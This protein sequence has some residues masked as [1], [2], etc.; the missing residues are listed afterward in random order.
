MSY[1]SRNRNDNQLSVRAGY[2]SGKLYHYNGDGNNFVQHIYTGIM[3]FTHMAGQREKYPAKV[4][5]ASPDKERLIASG[6][7]NRS[8]PRFLADALYDFVRTTSHSLFMHGI[9]LFEVVYEKDTSGN[10][11]SFKFEHIDEKYLF[12]LFGSY[13]QII[14]W[15]IA[16]QSHVRVQIVKIP[17]EKVFRIEFPK[18]LG[19]KRRLQRVLKR[20]WQLSK[21]IIPK[22]QM[23]AMGENK[24]IGFNFEDYKR[25]KYL[26]AATVTSCFGWNQ[27]QTSANYITEYYWFLRY[28]REVKTQTLVREEII[29][30]LNDCLSG[31]VL[32]LAV[33][34]LVE[35]LPTIALIEEQERLMKKGDMKFIDVY[36]S[37]KI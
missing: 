6:I 37:L 21:E 28:L 26:E 19:G 4:E 1:Y 25:G 24:N 7:S 16:K 18:K 8:Y 9:A 5:P 14:P 13:Y 10:L 23:D 22:F 31:P 29:S 30:R 15:W 17:S 20:L 34:V 32:N 3:P 35:N 33:K 27:G 36:N 12:R 2:H 11:T